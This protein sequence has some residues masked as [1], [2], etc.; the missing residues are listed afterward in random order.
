MA[1]HHEERDDFMEEN[2]KKPENKRI[3]IF[4]R[5]TAK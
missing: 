5:N 2:E 4:F 3:F 1:A